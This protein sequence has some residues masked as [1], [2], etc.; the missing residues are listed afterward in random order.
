MILVMLYY[1]VPTFNYLSDPINM[2][3]NDTTTIVR[4]NNA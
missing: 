3:V 4:N 1:T 2:L